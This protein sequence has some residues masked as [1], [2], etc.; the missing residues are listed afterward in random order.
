[1]LGQAPGA[2]VAS[3]ALGSYRNLFAGSLHVLADAGGYEDVDGEDN[4]GAEGV[5]FYGRFLGLW[6]LV[7]RGRFAVLA[8]GDFDKHDGL[9]QCESW[10]INTIRSGA[11]GAPTPCWQVWERDETILRCACQRLRT[12]PR[13]VSY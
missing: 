12:C 8:M 13:S 5:L 7:D 2:T 3:T 11:K 9:P 1:M 4:E 6:R 10:A